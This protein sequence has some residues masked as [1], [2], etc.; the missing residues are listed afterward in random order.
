MDIVCQLDMN[1]NVVARRDN[2]TLS[3]SRSAEMTVAAN[4]STQSSSRGA[5]RCFAPKSV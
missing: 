1:R 4:I 2:Q 5:A 3:Y